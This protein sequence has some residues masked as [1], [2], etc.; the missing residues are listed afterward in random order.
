[1]AYVIEASDRPEGACENVTLSEGGSATRTLVIS[2][3]LEIAGRVIGPPAA[4]LGAARVA[5]LPIEALMMGGLSSR[6]DEDRRFNLRVIASC[7]FALNV[8]GL[9]EGVSVTSIS[10]GSKVL[11]AGDLSVQ[12]ADSILI[13]LDNRH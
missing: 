1:M 4:S 6:V 10:I 8:S 12:E 13:R 2:G 9:P 11:S 5:A 3:P 7:H